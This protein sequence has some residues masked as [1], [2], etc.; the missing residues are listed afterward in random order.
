MDWIARQKHYKRGPD[1]AH[2]RVHVQGIIAC[3][4]LQFIQL[5]VHHFQHN[6]LSL[7]YVSGNSQNILEA[8]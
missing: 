6:Y 8:T 1:D 5:R 7:T 4:S 2:N 3:E